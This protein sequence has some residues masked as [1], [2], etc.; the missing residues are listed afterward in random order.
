MGQGRTVAIPYSPGD[1]V[2]VRMFSKRNVI[3]TML[4]FDGIP[5]YARK[6]DH[7]EVIMPGKR[8]VT[9]LKPFSKFPRANRI[10]P[11]SMFSF[12]KLRSFGKIIM[13]F[14]EVF[15]FRCNRSLF[16]IVL[17]EAKVMTN[18]VRNKPFSLLVQYLNNK[19]HFK[20]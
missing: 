9:V 13:G 5:P 20:V 10:S 11:S 14:F 7:A 15:S 12:Q 16:L 8:A 17:L 1:T 2:S 19:F 3:K 6:H 18:W 4:S